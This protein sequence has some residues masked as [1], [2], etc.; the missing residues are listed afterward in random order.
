MSGN[1]HSYTKAVGQATLSRRKEI[2]FRLG[3]GSDEI[4]KVHVYV[5]RIKG[6]QSMAKHKHG[7]KVVEESESVNGFVKT[8]FD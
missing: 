2:F 7:S 8:F 3:D 1:S 6:H 4:I 5:S